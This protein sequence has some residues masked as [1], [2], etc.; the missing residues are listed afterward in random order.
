MENINY[1]NINEFDKSVY[2]G[3]SIEKQE[4]KRIRLARQLIIISIKWLTENLG[5]KNILLG[6]GGSNIHTLRL[7]QKLSFYTFQVKVKMG[8]L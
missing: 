7:Y 3:V 8:Y 2:L 5:I 1:Y 6:V 4:Y